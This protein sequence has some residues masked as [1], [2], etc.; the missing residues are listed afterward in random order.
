MKTTSQPTD[1]I[2]IKAQANSDWDECHFA[3][4]H[5]SQEWKEQTQ[6][7]LKT[8]Q[9]IESEIGFVS[10]NYCDTAVD[11]YRTDED[12]LPEI[13]TILG[14]KNWSFVELD[15]NEQETFLVP[16]NRLD[17]FRISLYRYGT[18]MFS[19]YGKH[20]GE[21]FWTAEF[22]VSA[23]LNHHQ[24]AIKIIQLV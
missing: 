19:A 2:L 8:V 10:L 14:E 24:Q 11:F 23:I 18:A 16:E 12:D 6:Q 5:C 22:S 17:T 4:I 21:E 7:R 13:E 15:E 9:F 3:L 1:Y 20:S